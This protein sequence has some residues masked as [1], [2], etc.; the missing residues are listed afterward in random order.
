MEEYVITFHKTQICLGG[1]WFSH[2]DQFVCIIIQLIQ[3]SLEPDMKNPLYHSQAGYET[4][5]QY[6]DLTVARGPV[7]YESR[8]VDTRFGNT[9][10]LI[11]GPEAGA[12]VLLFHGWNGSAAGVGNEFP[13][14]FT[15]YRV[16]MPDIVGHAGKSGPNRPSPQGSNYADWAKDVLDALNLDKVFTL[17]ISGGGWM[18][19]KFSAYFP[20][21]VEKSVAL[22]TDGLSGSNTLAI[23]YWM[24]PAAIL[25]NEWTLLR[26]LSFTTSPNVK[27]TQA[28]SQG[29]IEAMSL[30]K[31]FKP[32]GNPG[33]LTDD[34]LRRIT[35]PFMLLMGEHERIFKPSESIERAKRLIPGLRAAEIVKDAGH[36]MTMDQPEIIME[37]VTSFFEQN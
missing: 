16:Y 31:H 10:I 15:K 11:G 12:P 37:K 22:S 32:Q 29:F 28:D 5:M 1:S 24:L 34:E 7:P 35:S 36:I 20:E 9:H 18:T 3:N 2:L 30:L 33:L 27:K 4:A 6:Y 8:T 17:G 14:L 13:F 21:H 26:F 25:P 19:L 23:L